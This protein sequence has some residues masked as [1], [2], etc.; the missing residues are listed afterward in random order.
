MDILKKITDYAGKNRYAILVL[1]IGVILMLLPFGRD[2]APKDQEVTATQP[3]IGVEEMLAQILGSIDG[4]GKVKVML[5]VEEGQTV[6]YQT[7]VGASSVDTVLV[8]G[9]DRS[10]TGLVKQTN[11]PKYRGAIIVCQGAQSAAVRL[12]IVE[13]VSKVTGLGTD[14]ISVLKMK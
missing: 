1:V 9:A 6:I 10:E 7:D 2:S 3:E 14:R 11:P 5:T 8:T 4:V 13:A 12:S